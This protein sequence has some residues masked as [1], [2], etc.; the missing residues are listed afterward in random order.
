M[1]KSLKKEPR[2]FPKGRD[3][4]SKRRYALRLYVAGLSPRSVRAIDNVKKI[5]EE[6]LKDRYCLD[7]IDL[8][9]QAGADKD[10]GII[11]APTLIK[12]TPLPLKKLIGDM[13]D[14]DKILRGLDLKPREK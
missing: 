2:Q 1:A 9:R 8:Y 5:C 4:R 10:D 3:A 6:Y 11:V 13:T 12:R 7:V 14:T